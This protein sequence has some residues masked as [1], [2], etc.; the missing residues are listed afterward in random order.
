MDLNLGSSA[1]PATTAAIALT[2]AKF[3]A[4]SLKVV[5]DSGSLI[6][7][8]NVSS[9][10]DKQATLKISNTRIANVYQTLA[11]GSIPL[12]NQSPNTSGQSIFIEL[13]VTGSRT[14]TSGTI[15][16]PM[17]ARVELRIP[18]DADIN[19]ADLKAL[20]LL[21]VGALCKTDGTFRVTE[22]MRGVLPP[23]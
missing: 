21:T 14:V 18:N 11:K 23:A 5:N 4:A 22:M 1:T 16:V 19:D 2:N 9:P 20:T 10:L 13:A 17:V 3:A 12:Q 6:K 8:A 15:L 7:L